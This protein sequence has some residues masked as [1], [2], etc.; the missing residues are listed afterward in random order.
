MKLAEFQDKDKGIIQ[1]SYKTDNEIEAIKDNLEK[2]SQGNERG[3][4]GT[5][6]M[7]EQTPMVPRKNMD[8]K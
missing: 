1:Q 2:G 4:T 3:S 5:M 7:E 6:P 8:T